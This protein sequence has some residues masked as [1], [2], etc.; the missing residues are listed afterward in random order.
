[1]QTT[2]A[3]MGFSNA[4]SVSLILA[5]NKKV[6]LQGAPFDFLCA[7]NTH[8]SVRPK[9]FSFD[10]FCQ[11][12]NSLKFSII[13][14]HNWTVMI[15]HIV[16]QKIYINNDRLLLRG[17]RLLRQDWDE[18]WTTHF[19][20]ENWPCNFHIKVNSV[21]DQLGFHLQ[22]DDGIHS[23]LVPTGPKHYARIAY[24][25][26]K[27]MKILF[28][29]LKDCQSKDFYSLMNDIPRAQLVLAEAGTS[30]TLSRPLFKYSHEAQVPEEFADIIKFDKIEL[31]ARIFLTRKPSLSG[32]FFSATKYITQRLQKNYTQVVA[33]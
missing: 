31:K 7:L 10:F 4:C 26:Q 21:T 28:Q 9:H 6:C 23:I 17:E 25:H 12:S 27:K 3:R 30:K 33:I 16:N 1:M 2:W 24:P 14:A 29:F 15:V 22:T 18:A 11:E 19:D 8:I 20:W 13:D 5:E 32:S